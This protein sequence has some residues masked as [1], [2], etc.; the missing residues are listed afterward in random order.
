MVTVVI[1]LAGLVLVAG[2]V[3]VVAGWVWREL[4]AGEDESGDD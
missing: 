1:A 2:L 3:R 4:H